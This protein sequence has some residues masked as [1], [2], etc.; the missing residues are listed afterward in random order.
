MKL[1][2][3]DYKLPKELIAQRPMERRDHSRLL[4]YEQG[5]V[6]HKHF[7]DLPNYL[8]AGDLLVLNDTKVFPARL[9][10]ARYITGGRI[11]VFLLKYEKGNTWECLVG[12]ARARAGLVIKFKHGLRAELLERLSNSWLI[13][14][15]QSKDKLLKIVDKIGRTPTP[16]YIKIQDSNEIRKSYQT[17]Y[18]KKTGSVAAPTAGFH[19]TEDL[20][21]KIKDRHVQIEYITLQV[22]LGTFAPVKTDNIK[23]HQMHSEY[24]EVNKGVW[25]R[26]NRAK[27]DGKRVISVG[28]TV[29]RVLESVADN[30]VLSGWTD[31]FIYPGFKFKIIDGLITNFHLPKSTLLMLVAAFLENKGVED[32]IKEIKKVYKQAINKEYRFFSFGDS[33][34]I[35]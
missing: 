28:T 23:E 9:I 5:K 12:H 17:V 27:K 6:K 22:G 8:Q 26:I 24:Y 11:E 35:L 19:F 7:Y 15:N 10:G 32:G 29:T 21:K 4:V 14:F 25:E 33:M 1:S 18:A 34:L 20:L 30:G 16:P 3:F 31:I 2:N 13:K